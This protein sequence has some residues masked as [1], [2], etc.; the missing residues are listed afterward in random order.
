M[1]ALMVM[2]MI[3]RLDT[4]TLE[5]TPIEDIIKSVEMIFEDGMTVDGFFRQA[6]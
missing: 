1:E 4:E 3:K 5:N 6:D 2:D